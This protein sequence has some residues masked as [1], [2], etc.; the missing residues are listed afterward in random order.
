MVFRLFCR[1]FLPGPWV[2]LFE[3]TSSFW[4]LGLEN[5][6]R[7]GED[8]ELV[9]TQ[10]G[11][12]SSLGGPA[13]ARANK[14]VNDGLLRVQPLSVRQ[15]LQLGYWKIQKKQD[16]QVVPSQKKTKKKDWVVPSAES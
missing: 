10:R 15:G 5:T 2:A 11:V 3:K 8:E 13:W 16:V 6:R 4:G 7:P 1:G 12:D 14:P 9:W